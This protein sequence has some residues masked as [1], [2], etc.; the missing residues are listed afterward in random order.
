[1]EVDDAT[2]SMVKSSYFTK[3]KSYLEQL[4]L[5]L[6]E[7][8]YANLLLSNHVKYFSSDSSIV[9]YN[10]QPAILGVNHTIHVETRR[11]LYNKN[12]LVLVSTNFRDI[13]ELLKAERLPLVSN[14]HLENFQQYCLH[15]RMKFVDRCHSLSADVQLL[16][17]AE[18]L[19]HFVRIVLIEYYIFHHLY[20]F[21]LQLTLRHRGS[22]FMTLSM[23]KLLLDPFIQFHD[24]ICPTR[25][26]GAVN[27]AYRSKVL[28]QMTLLADPQDRSRSLYQ[29]AQ[30]LKKDADNAAQCGDMVYARSR[31]SRLHMLLH[32][33]LR[34]EDGS[35]IS[36]QWRVAFVRLRYRACI[37][38][39]LLYLREK[40]YHKIIC[41]IKNAFG[42]DNSL[43]PPHYL[44]KY[45]HYLGLCRAVCSERVN[46]GR[47]LFL[48]EGALRL[49]PDNTRIRASLELFR[50]NFFTRT[51]EEDGSPE[52]VAVMD[53]FMEEVDESP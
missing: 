1:M 46:D 14:D 45:K 53:K 7:M 28:S 37:N 34:W 15:V 52:K 8:I 10:V 32:H 39:A 29:L 22:G 21:R 19:P 20:H 24:G 25:I 13:F 27:F 17:L 48:F 41:T 40:D 44:A 36:S 16:M 30:D 31:Y 26:F 12:A 42:V 51:G 18:N 49:D 6:R 9:R 47:V 33:C 38:E 35:G 5:E 23:Q 50:N 4:P 11:M 3:D 2:T 43:I